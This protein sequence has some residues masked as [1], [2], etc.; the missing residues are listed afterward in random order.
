MDDLDMAQILKDLRQKLPPDEKQLTP[1]EER[2]LLKF[3][4]SEFRDCVKDN[5][6]VIHK[7]A[8]HASMGDVL[9]GMASR[10]LA[11]SEAKK[12]YPYFDKLLSKSPFNIMENL[13]IHI[14]KKLQ[15]LIP[16][17]RVE[18]DKISVSSFAKYYT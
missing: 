15:F 11:V 13:P 14:V 3:L 18:Y 2:T 4:D 7:Y 16:G 17:T 8:P 1:Q 10:F 6:D 12:E 9:G 5:L